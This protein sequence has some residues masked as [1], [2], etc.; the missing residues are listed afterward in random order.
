MG[1]FE[2][3]FRG[4]YVNQVEHIRELDIRKEK[5]P[6]SDREALARGIRDEHR[7]GKAGKEL[8]IGER[9]DSKLLREPNEQAPFVSDGRPPVKGG[10]PEQGVDRGLVAAAKR[11]LD[12]N[13]EAIAIGA[14]KI[15]EQQQANGRPLS[16]KDKE[17]ILCEALNL[18]RV[19]ETGD[20]T[21]ASPITEGRVLLEALKQ[22]E[23]SLKGKKR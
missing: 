4:G 1:D 2:N 19:D 11:L 10:T 8:K 9:A 17:A 20:S 14:A 6:I 3:K 16:R 5:L 18:S 12:A 15:A 22:Y 23:A 21:H 7:G 13:R